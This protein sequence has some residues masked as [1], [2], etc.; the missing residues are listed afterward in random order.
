MVGGGA[1]GAYR[2]LIRLTRNF[3]NMHVYS[4]FGSNLLLSKLNSI[5]VMA[6]E[7]KPKVKLLEPHVRSLLEKASKLRRRSY[8]ESLD[9]YRITTGSDPPDSTIF[10]YLFRRPLYFSILSAFTVTGTAVQ[11]EAPSAL[12][13]TTKFTPKP[14]SLTSPAAT[15]TQDRPLNLFVSPLDSKAALLSTS[16]AFFSHDSS[17]LKSKEFTCDFGVDREELEE[18]SS[19]VDATVSSPKS[20][21]TNS[22]NALET[23]LEIQSFSTK[24]N[25]NISQLGKKVLHE[26]RQKWISKNPQTHCFEKVVSLSANKLGTDATLNVFGRLGRENCVKEYNSLIRICIE[27]AKDCDYEDV[28]LE[29]ICKAFQLFNLMKEQGFQLEGET[30][31]TL[32]MYLIYMGMIEE[33]H[34]FRKAIDSGNSRSDPRLGYYEMLLWIRVNDEEKIQELCSCTA[35]DYEGDYFN[36]IGKNYLLALCE[37]KR[38]REFVQLL[39]TVDITKV[40]SLD[41]VMSIFKFLGR[42]VLAYFAEKYLVELTIS[43]MYMVFSFSMIWKLFIKHL[44]NAYLHNL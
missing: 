32:L 25:I 38:K 14:S 23:E 19:S 18:D 9:N 7:L 21:G 10:T 16:V 4:L 6:V 34:F 33:F 36:L 15:T 20:G 24:S 39:E 1:L 3:L 31:G 44:L 35:I 43:G 27:R 13:S 42:L 22:A 26:R 30:Y 12:K 40:S 37:S 41:H 28:A 8:I 11:V 2:D 17:K 5:K 29:Q